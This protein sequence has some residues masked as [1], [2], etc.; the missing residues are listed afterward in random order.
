MNRAALARILNRT[1]ETGAV[2]LADSPNPV[3]WA[4]ASLTVDPRDRLWALLE[5]WATL[6]ET[7]WPEANVKALYED[8]MDIFR[9]HREAEEWYRGWRA[10]HPQGKL[11]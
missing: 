5:V 4:L 2:A 3:E 1:Q 8:I 10:A 6:D 11:W 7:E 9:D